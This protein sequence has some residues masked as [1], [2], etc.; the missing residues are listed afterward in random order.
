MDTELLITWNKETFIPVI[1]NDIKW[2]TVRKGAP[3]KLVFDIVKDDV[4]SFQEG[5]HVAFRWRGHDIFYGFVF[6]KRRDKEGII[7]VTAYDQLRYLK[8]K[9]TY[10]YEDKTA[11]E[12]LG[13][14]AR[15]FRLQTGVIA[16]TGYKI[17][18]RVEDN[19]TLFD[20]IQN[21]LDLTITNTKELYVLYDDFGKIALKSLEDMRT[22]ILIA[23]D[24][25]GDFRYSSS[26]DENTYNTIKLVFDNKTTGKRD[27]YI[28]RSGEN[29]NNWGVLQYYDKLQEGEDGQMKAQALLQLYNQR[30]RKLTIRDCLGDCRVRAGSLVLVSLSLGD[31]NMNNWM[32]VEGCRHRFEQDEHW[33]DI[34]VRGG[35]FIG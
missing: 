24:T 21:A 12:L 13:M 14:I 15:D 22:D 3:S 19:Q 28:E 20:I 5:A 35:E 29:I 9:D 18:H 33:M 23:S 10:V 8:N 31:L 34:D 17:P 2:T 25:A 30:A 27:V 11:A 1:A 6:T 4:I 32:V 7:S 16:D 26:I